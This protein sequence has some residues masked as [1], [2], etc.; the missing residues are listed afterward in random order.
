MNIILILL[1]L[2]FRNLHVPSRLSNWLGFIIRTNKRQYGVSFSGSGEHPIKNKRS[3]FIT[4]LTFELNLF[5]VKHEYDIND[6]QVWSAA[7]LVELDEAYTRWVS[8]KNFL[9]ILSLKRK[10]LKL[11]KPTRYP[12]H[13]KIRTRTFKLCYNELYLFLISEKVFVDNFSFATS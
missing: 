3:N 7:T 9:A 4:G 2:V 10:I 11:Y 1:G 12:V 8:M 5:K 6:R 13:A